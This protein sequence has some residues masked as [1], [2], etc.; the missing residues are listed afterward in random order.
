[1]SSVPG[2]AVVNYGA[3]PT[4][5]ADSSASLQSLFESNNLAY[6]P[7]GLYRVDNEVDLPIP[8]IVWCFGGDSIA[9][10]FDDGGGVNFGPGIASL[11][12]P[13]EQVAFYTTNTDPNFNMFTI[14]KASVKWRGGC[15]DFQN[16]TGH[17]GSAFF[18]DLDANN[19]NATY[20]PWGMDTNAGRANGREG[21]IRGVTVMGDTAGLRTTNPGTGSSA[22][23][24]RFPPA[25]DTSTPN[26]NIF[27]TTL[28]WDVKGLG[29]DKVLDLGPREVFPIGHWAN[30]SHFRVDAHY[31]RQAVWDECFFGV[32]WYINHWAGDVF[33][34]EANALA[35]PSIY[36]TS[37]NGI[38]YHPT[39]YDFRGLSGQTNQ[40]ATS[41][42]WYNQK[43]FKLI[44]GEFANQDGAGF[45]YGLN[46][47]DYDRRISMVK[48]ET[49]RIYSDVQLREGAQV[50]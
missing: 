41:G 10:G 47:D 37:P 35:T 43:T 38:Y 11:R 39:F 4:G 45:V 5:I 23:K 12:N 44:S 20:K 21:M 19:G 24:V 26:K 16:L 33:N 9:T 27:L 8:K 36:S 17:N 6:I 42:A 32:R 7:P 18:Y 14:R 31:C 25:G 22:I 13:Y 29:L 46:Q 15:V 40:D 1:M 2:N 3:D 34:T 49:M 28:R 30:N 50:I 48:Q